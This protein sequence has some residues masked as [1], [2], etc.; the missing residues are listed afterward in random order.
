MKAFAVSITSILFLLLTACSGSSQSQGVK[1]LDAQAF[2]QQLKKEPGVVL[3]VRT[4]EE[5]SEGH[6]PNAQLLNFYDDDFR[7]KLQQLDKDK[8]YYV[9]CRSG[10]RSSRAVALMKE[11]GFK[12]VYNLKGGIMQWQAQK[13]PVER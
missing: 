13:L 5:Y 1:D 11:L 9:Y 3:D 2:A 12:K 4:P 6:L 8:T 7:S 10:G